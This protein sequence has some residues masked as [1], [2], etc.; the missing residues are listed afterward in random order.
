MFVDRDIEVSKSIKQTY[1]YTY[2][3][4]E[5]IPDFKELWLFF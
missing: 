1:I 4:R 2:K 3:V 5:E